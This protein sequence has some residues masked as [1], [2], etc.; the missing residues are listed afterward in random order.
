VKR[1]SEVKVNKGEIVT[2]DIRSW[3]LKS[4]TPITRNGDG[5]RFAPFEVAE[6]TDFDGLNRTFTVNAKDHDT[7]A[8]WFADNSFQTGDRDAVARALYLQPNMPL[9]FA[10]IATSMTNKIREGANATKVYG[11][12][13]R[14]ETYIHVT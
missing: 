9:T 14:E 6:N 12:S 10:S 13:Y 11:T 4:P 5:H 3:P 2:P 1:Y 8:S 7:L